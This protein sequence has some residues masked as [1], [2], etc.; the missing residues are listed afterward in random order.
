MS[1]IGKF[2]KFSTIAFIHEPNI[3]VL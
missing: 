1:M 2:S 3:F